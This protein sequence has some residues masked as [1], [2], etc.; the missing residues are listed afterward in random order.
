[1]TVLDPAIS[2]TATALL[3]QL[4]K[5][6]V[7]YAKQLGAKELGRASVDLETGFKRFLDRNLRQYS[8]IKTLIN[9]GSPT[10]LD[11]AFESPNLNIDNELFTEDQFLSFIDTEQFAVIV[12]TG[13]SGK[14]V[15][16]KHLFIRYFNEP[17][18]RIPL[19]V[20]LRNIS[21]GQTILQ[22]IQGLL[23]S[24][25]PAF[26]DD[27]LEYALRS[28]KFALLFD[29]FDEID[30]ADRKTVAEQI[31][32]ITYSYGDN[33]LILTSRPD[34]I[35]MGWTEF[36]IAK[37][38]G[39]TKPQVLS[40]LR[41]T[42]YDS[43]IKKAFI[44]LIKD[45]SLY[46]T[47]GEFL[48]NPLL[49]N[50]MLLTFDQGAEI[51]T[52]MHVFFGQTFDVLFYRH[53]ATKGTSYRRKFLSALSIDEFRATTAAF[54]TFSYLDFGPTMRRD[55]VIAS[56]KKA[57]E[58]CRLNEKADNLIHD[59]CSSVSILIKDGDVFSYIHRAFQEYFVA[60]F[61]SSREVDDYGDIIQ[62]L[63]ED[64]PN[65]SVVDLLHDINRDRFEREFL[66]PRLAE[67]CDEID[68]ID[69]K[70]SPSQAFKLFYYAFG[71]TAGRNTVTSWTVG[72]NGVRPKWN[73]MARFLGES[74]F[75]VTLSRFDWVR[76]LHEVQPGQHDDDEELDVE[77]DDAV[78][79]NTPM[80]EYLQRLRDN[81]VSLR[82]AIGVDVNTQKKLLSDALL[83]RA[84]KQSAGFRRAGKVQS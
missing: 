3:P 39:F 37:M 65:D 25:S 21:S 9:P 82:A 63:L 50:I 1:V 42:R 84:P 79:L 48:S 72:R 55:A 38:E 13:G 17:R 47:H 60:L 58:Y 62:R 15:F 26:S 22:H 78:L 12:G 24:V 43:A 29:G 56:A 36:T 59:L 28:G 53:D 35:F 30:Y 49:C 5:D 18:G 51:P 67:L 83:K 44:K 33:L 10:P 75:S 46:E 76:H 73:Y 64:K 45:G 16:L 68:K 34:E 40:L 61:L 77:P 14:S 20:E 66:A 27:M 54:S 71:V 11:S 23:K 80:V 2:A 52:M 57:I 4:A 70:E 7:S 6:L 32:G 31:I 81:A 19:L 74:G 41:K 8:R 69:I